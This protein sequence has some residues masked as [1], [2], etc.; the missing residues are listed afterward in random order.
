MP[1]L[2]KFL[3]EDPQAIADAIVYLAK[4]P[5]LCNSL[6]KQGRQYVMT[7][8]DR[9]MIAQNFATMIEQLIAKQKK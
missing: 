4:Y 1:Y 2:Q 8:Y 5:D 3:P 7:H 9:S 6:G